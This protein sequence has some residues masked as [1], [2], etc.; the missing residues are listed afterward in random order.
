MQYRLR[1]LLI[2]LAVGPP[3]L[4]WAWINRVPLSITLTIILTACVLGTVLGRTLLWGIEGLLTAAAWLMARLRHATRP[5]RLPGPEDAGE[6]SLSR[7]ASQ[8]KARRKE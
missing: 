1:T 2:L 4:A 3:V 6:F 5:K 7:F 8:V